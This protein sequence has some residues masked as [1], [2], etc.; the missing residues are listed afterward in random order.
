VVK[1]IVGKESL[2]K[3]SLAKESYHRGGDRYKHKW[4][5]F[6]EQCRKF[7]LIAYWFETT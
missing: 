5:C 1:K 7:H 2:V 6:E 3:K 4:H